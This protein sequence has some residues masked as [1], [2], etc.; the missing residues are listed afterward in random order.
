MSTEARSIA[1]P[2]P[3]MS[4]PS[5]RT[6]FLLEGPIASTLLRLAAPN[7]IVNVVLIAVTAT[8]DAHFVGR[9]GSEAL[10]GLSLVFPLIMLMQQ[11]A[12]SSMGGAIASA[13][14]RAIGAGRHADASAL[15]VHG[16][17]IAAGM[18][19]IFASILLI[20][21][22][23]I[24][25]L[26]SGTGDTL[27]AALEYSNAIFAGALAY[28]LLST[29]TSVVRGAGEATVLAV[30]YLA[31]EA[32]HIVLVPILMFGVGPLPPLGITGA[33]IATVASFS[34]SSAVLAWYIAS[35]RTAITLS[36]RDVRLDR[37]LFVEIL[38]VG[39]PMSLQPILNN[40]ALALLTGF[41][42]TLGAAHLAGFGAA[43]RLEYLLYPLAFGLGGGVLSMVGTNIAAGNFSRASR[44]TL[45]ASALAAGVTGCIGLFGV[46]APG[47]WTGLFTA[48]PH[49]HVL[50]ADYLVIAGLS[51]PFLGL[52]LTLAASFQAAGRPLW[53]LLGVTGR[54]LVVIIGGWIAVHVAGTSISHLA[55]VAA[56]GLIVYGTSLTIAFRAGAWR[57]MTAT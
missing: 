1:Q 2:A 20:G 41:V 27:A 28:W 39:A 13:I 30:V 48:D 9:M 3:K 45:T 49:V 42:G 37:R 8:V 35:G 56:G 24:Y 11:M 26:M 12:N 21:G 33:G 47:T 6:R 53:P 55:L 34:A 15:V 52:G 22:P 57:T 50:A 36:L 10:A 5:A 31:A 25:G 29:L 40:L 23:V 54:A 18:A 44:I 51:Y 4:A 46:M 38:R 43:V 17:I 7:V 14:A 16:I 19:A 32:L